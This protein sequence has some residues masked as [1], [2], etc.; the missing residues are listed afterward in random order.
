MIIVFG[1]ETRA[2]LL[3]CAVY[4]HRCGDYLDKDAIPKSVVRDCRRLADWLFNIAVWP[5]KR[6]GE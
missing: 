4:I 2:K 6:K 3:E 5:K 1:K